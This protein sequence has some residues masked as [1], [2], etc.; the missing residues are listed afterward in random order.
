MEA[1]KIKNAKDVQDKF[2]AVSL[3]Q[4]LR[5]QNLSTSF[6]MY[7]HSQLRSAYDEAA[8]FSSKGA[9][10]LNLVQSCADTLLNRITKHKPRPTFLTSNGDWDMMVK[11]Q[12]LEKYVFGQFYR[13]NTYKKSKDAAL[14][15][16]V[17]GD[18][19]VKVYSENGNP[20]IEPCLTPEL[21]FDERESVYGKPKSMFQMR[22]VSKEILQD[23][24]PKLAD[25]IENVNPARSPFYM[26][27]TNFASNL[28]PV[29]EYWKLP[30][31]S[32]KGE[33]WMVC[34]ELELEQ[35]EWKRKRFPFAQLGFVKNLVGPYHKGVAEI[36]KSHQI[37][38]NRTLKRI[39]DSL[40]LVAS[41]KVLYDFQSK[42]I[43]THFNNDVGTM[44]GYAGTAP[45]FVI[46][47]AV[48]PELFNH[49]QWTVQSAYQEVGVSELS[50]GSRK[51]AGLDS[52]KALR[53]YQDIESERFSAF[54]TAWDDFHLDVADLLIEEAS[55]NSASVVLAPSK[56]GAETIKFSDVKIEKD[57]YIMQS[58][59]SAM[60][61]KEPAG[62]LAYVQ[63]MLGSKLIP[64]EIGAS[65][66]EFPDIESWTSLIN[67]PIDDIKHTISYMIE[68]GE[69][70]PP[71]ENQKIDDI[72]IAM[73]GG[74]YLKYK[75]QG[76]PQDRLDL[77]F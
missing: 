25:K 26:T 14:Q 74:A 11:A 58:Y 24:Y 77:I 32:S 1:T 48:G 36:I 39:S 9:V 53:E 42:I 45:Q 23:L 6:Y 34:E 19:F 20:I 49:L 13:T 8:A 12:K 66:L 43:K 57:C 15:A 29:I 65:L 31:G 5:G 38:V 28:I 62:R 59:P 7:G 33:H 16:L 61:P 37:E 35:D 69:Y 2:L 54:V 68:K 47:P 63:E 22:L 40:R 71:E 50:A 67:S 4:S 55:A 44:I 46:P 73:M 17:Y 3:D 10:K 60:L 21:M 56:Y 51:P 52:G 64:P 72:S 70:L 30:V 75:N 27:G 41:P 76:C 18:G